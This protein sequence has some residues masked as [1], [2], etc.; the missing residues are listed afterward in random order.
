MLK[1]FFIAITA[2]FFGSVVAQEIPNHNLDPYNPEFLE[3]EILIKFHDETDVSIKTE[4]GQLKTGIKSFDLLSEKLEVTGLEKLFKSAQKR[5]TTKYIKTFDGETRE[6][7]QLFNIYK[8]KIAAK[9]NLKD[10]IKE[11]QQDPNVEY[12]EPNYLCY[13]M[14][15]TPN[16]PNYLNG[17]Q[18]YINAVNAPAAWDVTTGSSNQ[19]IAIID[20]GG[21][22]DAS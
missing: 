14:E 21:G 12:A 17:S 22:L 13:T 15:T 3:G 9:G 6:V 4:K 7:K 2:M 20:T 18:W 16:D 10:V 8:L 11:L 5:T 1:V 19:L